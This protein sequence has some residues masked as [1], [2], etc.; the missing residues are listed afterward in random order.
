M[1]KLTDL[2]FSKGTIVETILTTYDEK[3]A[4]NAA[5]MGIIMNNEKALSARIYKSSLTYRNLL[6]KKSA[7]VNITSDVDTFLRTTFKDANPE[8]KIPNDWFE[9]AKIVD[10]P[11]LRKSDAVVEVAVAEMRPIDTEKTELICRVEL[12]R[13]EKVFPKA[14]CRA[15]SATIEALIHATRINAF[16]KGDQKQ[17]EKALQLVK[18]LASIKET[19]DH[20]SPESRYAEIMTYIAGKI[21]SWREQNESLR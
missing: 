9:R 11:R 20:V 18:T 19:V 14:Y 17:R 13:A 8:G 4:P 5:P 3:G 10:A 6:S 15:H 1:V 7:V 16:L 21:K 12:I 2:G